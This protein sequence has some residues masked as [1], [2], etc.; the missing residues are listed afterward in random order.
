[1]ILARLAKRS[2]QNLVG[3]WICLGIVTLIL[4]LGFGGQCLIQAIGLCWHPWRWAVYKAPVRR[5][6]LSLQSLTLSLCQE[7]HSAH[8][9]VVTDQG[10]GGHG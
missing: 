5:G 2:S 1:M 3:V 10:I 7:W 8:V 4:G 9:Q 6:H